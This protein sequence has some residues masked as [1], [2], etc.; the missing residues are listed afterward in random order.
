MFGDYQPEPTEHWRTDR[1]SRKLPPGD[2]GGMS[3]NL[4]CSSHSQ[5]SINSCQPR[6][7]SA[8]AHHYGCLNKIYSPGTAA[9]S[10]PTYPILARICA[11]P[12]EQQNGCPPTW[13]GQ[14]RDGGQYKQC[15]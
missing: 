9:S 12:L 7:T 10:L 2:Q 6:R 8:F 1:T 3:V 11:L 4:E 14:R 5:T 13:Q 15:F